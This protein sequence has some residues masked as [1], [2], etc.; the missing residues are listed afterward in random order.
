MTPPRVEGWFTIDQ[1][2]E[3]AH[4]ANRSLQGLLG[5]EVSPP[6]DQLDDEMKASVRHG[7]RVVQESP[8]NGAQE[9]HRQWSIVRKS[10]GWVYGPVKHAGKKTHPNL[11]DWERLPHLQR[12]KDQL[13]FGVVSSLLSPERM[14][15]V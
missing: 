11:V 5:E 2:A 8:L 14:T 1:L 4:D 6:W 10:Q 13:F 7:V 9:L 3:I 15:E 12:A